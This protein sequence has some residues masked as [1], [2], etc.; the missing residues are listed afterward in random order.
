MAVSSARVASPVPVGDSQ[1]VQR[2]E[3]IFDRQSAWVLVLLSGALTAYT[4]VVLAQHRPLTD[5]KPPLMSLTP[6]TP[7]MSEAKP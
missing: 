7:S 3:S 4:L 2:R 5:S 6:L 1:P